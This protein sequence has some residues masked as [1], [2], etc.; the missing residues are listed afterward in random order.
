MLLTSD[1]YTAARGFL[2]GPN[3]TAVG[4]K[5]LN[6]SVMLRGAAGQA[7]FT[8]SAAILG[9]GIEVRYSGGKW[10]PTTTQFT[11]IMTSKHSLYVQG[12]GG[13]IPV[14]D[15]AAKWE[16]DLVAG[17]KAINIFYSN[18]G[19]NAFGSNLTQSAAI[20]HV[21]P[22]FEENIGVATK[23]IQ[24]PDSASSDGTAFQLVNLTGTTTADGSGIVKGTGGISPSDEAT[25]WT[26]DVMILL[27]KDP[28]LYTFASTAGNCD[29][30]AG[31]TRDQ[32]TKLLTAQYSARTRWQGL[33]PALNREHMQITQTGFGKVTEQLL[34]KSA[35]SGD[36]ITLPTGEKAGAQYERLQYKLSVPTGQMEVDTYYSEV[37]GGSGNLILPNTHGFILECDG[38]NNSTNSGDSGGGVFVFPKAPTAP[39]TRACLIGVTTGSAVSTKRSEAAGMWDFDNNVVTSLGLYYDKLFDL[40]FQNV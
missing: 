26:Y 12:N 16:Q 18:S 38:G 29:Y 28:T 33:V 36:K 14:A 1:H 34:P 20:D 15:G 4:Q 11:V 2:T 32:L 22:I 30:Q 5:T 39:S 13:T 37:P 10:T 8:G 9:T 21:V 27:S 6:A 19:T 23:M 25:A 40:R 3:I 24:I 31:A 7:T 17:F 35:T